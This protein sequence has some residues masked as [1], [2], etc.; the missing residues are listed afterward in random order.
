MPRPSVLTA[1]VAALLLAPAALRAADSDLASLTL[2]KT[3]MGPPATAAS[4]GGN[5]VMVEFWGTH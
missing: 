1:C 5:V 2:G 4:L 3:L